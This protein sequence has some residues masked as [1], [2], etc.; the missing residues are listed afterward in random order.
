VTNEDIV[1]TIIERVRPALNADGGDIEILGINDS[2]VRVKLTG[3]CAGCP[4]AEMTLRLGIEAAVRRVRP[5]LR[6]IAEP[7]VAG[8]RR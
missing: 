6:V 5:N 3:A 7:A 2:I 8:V 1:E 4:S